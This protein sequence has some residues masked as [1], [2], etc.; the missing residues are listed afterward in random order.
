MRDR[1]VPPRPCSR[2]FRGHAALPIL[3][4][5]VAAA[6]S[7]GS[8]IT[9]PDP[10]ADLRVLFIGNSLTATNDL[11]A[12]VRGIAEADGTDLAYAS[13]LVPGYS[14]EDHWRNGVEDVIRDAD[15]D[16]VVLQQG[17][18]SLPDN[19][20][21]LE[22][23]TERYAPVVAENGGQVALYM[24]WP[25]SHRLYALDAVREAYQRA[26][27]AVG[28]LFA[29]AG[30]TWR[31]VLESSAP[32]RLYGPDGFHPTRTGTFAAALTIYGTLRA[33]DG[34]LPCPALSSLGGE[35]TSSAREAVCLAAEET[36]SRFGG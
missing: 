35:L 18:S 15:A 21:H 9:A 5:L 33:G 13:V 6:C 36:L 1:S 26:A 17:P 22:R 11:P 29:P 32:V 34:D 8:S 2:L 7:T 24:V 31:S 30:E 20:E 28:G 16:V 25:A 3:F 10:D 4:V 14:L 19:Q 12:M 27:R 23:W